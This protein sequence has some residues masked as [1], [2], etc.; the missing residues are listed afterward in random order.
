MTGTRCKAKSKQS[1]E[2][3]KRFATP[4][5]D[6]CTSHGSKSPQVIAK[7]V[8]FQEATHARDLLSRLGSPDPIRHPVIELLEVAAEIK[9]WQIILRE[10]VAELHDLT[11]HDA[12]FVE[13]ERAVVALY[14]RSLDR[15]TRIL[16]DMTKLDLESKQLAVSRRDFAVILDCCTRAFESLGLPDRFDEWKIAYATALRQKETDR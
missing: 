12:L 14:E 10:R 3:C 2:R 7:I 5:A 16:T 15:T 1:G 13:R 6:V 8:R 9:A 4:G 11:S